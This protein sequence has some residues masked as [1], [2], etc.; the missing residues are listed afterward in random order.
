MTRK[1]AIL[2]LLTICCYTLSA[3]VTVSV[4]TRSH[5]T[6]QYTFDPSG[7]IYFNGDRIVVMESL[8][9]ASTAAYDIDDVSKVAFDGQFADII[10]TETPALSLRPNPAQRGVTISGIGSKPQQADIYNAA[11][12]L[13]LSTPVCDGQEIDVSSLAPGLYFVSLVGKTLK[14]SIL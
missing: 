13:M 10:P 4:E 14:L 11:G 3:Q 7:E 2:M 6:D 5:G 8:L 1:T 9:T 12:V